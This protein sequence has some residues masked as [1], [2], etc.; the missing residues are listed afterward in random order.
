MTALFYHVPHT[1]FISYF[2]FF[3]ALIVT[4][5]SDLE[6]MLISRYATLFLVP[7]GFLL[8]FFNLLPITPQQSI[9][10]TLGGYLL[11]FAIAKLFYYFTGKHGLGQG[12]VDLIAFVGSFIGFFGAW[13][14]ILVGS[15]V[16]SF[17]GLIYMLI[18]RTGYGMKIPFGP[19]LA[20]GAISYIFLQDYFLKLLVIT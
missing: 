13:A 15:V 17:I 19:F 6:T 5:R 14:T 18:V 8:S 16:G 2:I 12:D 1:F 20:G 7:V 3:S 9:I 10:G 11:L 4:I